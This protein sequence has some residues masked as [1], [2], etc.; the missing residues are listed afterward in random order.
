MEQ[1]E[2]L[3]LEFAIERA[4]KVTQRSVVHEKKMVLIFADIK[5]CEGGGDAFL[6]KDACVVAVLASR[7]HDKTRDSYSRRETKENNHVL[8]KSMVCKATKRKTLRR[9]ALD[10]VLE[11][12]SWT[13]KRGVK[14]KDDDIH[15]TY[16]YNTNTKRFHSIIQ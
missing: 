11:A 5:M 1:F 10:D 6:G 16:T 7:E 8:K 14:H 15:L 13:W 12:S 2:Q 4:R 3:G 9:D